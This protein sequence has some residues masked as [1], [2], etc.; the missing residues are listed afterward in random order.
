MLIWQEVGCLEFDVDVGVGWRLQYTALLG[1]SNPLLLYRSHVMVVVRTEKGT[2]F[3][4]L[5]IKSLSFGR[6][7]GEL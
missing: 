3:F 7:V 6:P 4:D 2:A 1:V 5:M